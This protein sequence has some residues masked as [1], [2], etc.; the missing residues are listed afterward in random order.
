MFISKETILTKVFYTTY[1]ISYLF[2][3]LSTQNIEEYTEPVQGV[4]LREIPKRTVKRKW[5]SDMTELTP[6]GEGQELKGWT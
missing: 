2:Y 5:G 4:G 3:T 6:S 1:H